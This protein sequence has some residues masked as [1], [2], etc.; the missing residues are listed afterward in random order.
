MYILLLLNTQGNHLSTPPQLHSLFKEEVDRHI[1]YLT[2]WMP[3]YGRKKPLTWTMASW[4]LNVSE[5]TARNYVDQGKLKDLKIPTI[6]EFIVLEEIRELI[7]E[8]S[9]DEKNRQHKNTVT[10]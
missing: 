8:E 3:T 1:A 6:A 5:M 9:I 10:T 7:K 4:A 2:K